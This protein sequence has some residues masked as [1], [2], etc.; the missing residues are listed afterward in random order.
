MYGDGRVDVTRLRGGGG[1]WANTTTGKRGR[2]RDRERE[3][4]REKWKNKEE[5]N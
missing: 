3:R 1:R 4:G 2:E 5:E